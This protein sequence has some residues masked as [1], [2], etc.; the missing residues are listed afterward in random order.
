MNHTEFRKVSERSATDH[1]V[2][3]DE[4]RVRDV[5]KVGGENAIADGHGGV[6]NGCC[7]RVVFPRV[8]RQRRQAGIEERGGVGEKGEELRKKRGQTSMGHEETKAPS[9]VSGHLC[10]PTDAGDRT[11]AVL[12]SHILHGHMDVGGSCARCTEDRKGTEQ[13]V[14]GRATA[15]QEGQLSPFWLK[16]SAKMDPPPTKLMSWKDEALCW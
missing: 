6:D 15:R 2:V 3:A 13:P 16:A 7:V 14:Q 5:H 11:E 1:V 10:V 12:S 9:H 8:R 4:P